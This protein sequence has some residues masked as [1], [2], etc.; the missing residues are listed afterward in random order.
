MAKPFTLGRGLSSLIP[1]KKSDGNNFWGGQGEERPTPA[2]AQQP[3]ARVTPGIQIQEISISNIEANPEQPR[4]E[5]DPGALAELAASIKEHGVLQPLVVCSAASGKY[6]LIA[7]ERRWRAARMAG[8][9]VVPVIVRNVAEQQKLE[10]ALVENLQREDLNPL[11]EARAYQRL[12]DEFN[13]TQEE[14]GKRVGKSRSQVAN[15]ER[16]LGLPLSVQ[17][18]LASGKITVGHAKVLLSLEDPAEQQKFFEAI[19]SEGLPVRL[20]DAKIRATSVRTH[21]RNV[22]AKNPL[23]QE[24]E[25]VLEGYL[26]TRVRIKG[27]AKQGTIEVVFYS[28]EE[29]DSLAKKLAGKK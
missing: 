2:V 5:F 21:M 1:Q 11:E 17:Q 6:Q 10:L 26:G 19:V 24:Y 18:A 16:L 13:L 4:R 25:R 29:L 14:V 28:P 9:S 20:A 7:G 23:W 12:H 15:T 8:L 22:K 3:V 27:T